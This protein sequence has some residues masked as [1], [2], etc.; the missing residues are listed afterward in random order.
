MDLKYIRQIGTLKDSRFKYTADT[1]HIN[2]MRSTKCRVVV[3]TVLIHEGWRS[4]GRLDF[5]ISHVSC[6]AYKQ[7]LDKLVCFYKTLFKQ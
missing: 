7:A 4:L 5:D 3:A 6:S 1:G 2:Q